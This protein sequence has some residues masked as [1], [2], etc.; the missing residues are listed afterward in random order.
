MSTLTDR[1]SQALVVIDVQNEVIDQT[2]DRD[3]VVTRIA[4]LVEGARSAGVPVV[5]VQHQDD[6]LVAGTDGWALVSELVPVAGE[7]R[8]DKRFR[9]S[10]EDTD[11]ES[12]LAGVRAAELVV[13]GAET[14]NCVRHTIHAALEK[15]YDVTLVSDAHTTW[16]GTWEN[17]AIDGAA[18]IAEQNRNFEDYEL[19]GR[20]CRTQSA[21]QVRQAWNV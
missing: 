11:L 7:P 4:A 12:A 2:Y 16:H 9:S 14:N 17:V 19:P 1:S 10:F 6:Y 5:W 8:I 13:C 3:A 18:I 21:D 15:G 20:R